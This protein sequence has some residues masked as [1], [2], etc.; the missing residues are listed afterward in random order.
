LEQ[1]LAPANFTVVLTTDNAAGPIA[2]LIL[3]RECKELVIES[4]ADRFV[5]E[6]LRQ[7]FESLGA[8]VVVDNEL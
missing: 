1:G 8:D 4:A 7:F 3:S 5:A 6:P 2:R